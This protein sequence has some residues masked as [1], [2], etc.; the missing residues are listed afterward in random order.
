MD[1]LQQSNEAQT[2]DWEKRYKDSSREAVRMRDEMK[3]IKPFVP[4]LDAMKKDRK[5]GLKT[6]KSAVKISLADKI[7]K[8]QDKIE[9]IVE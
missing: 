1:N 5:A 7:Q 2:V 3:E 9:S 6:K 4:I 8:L